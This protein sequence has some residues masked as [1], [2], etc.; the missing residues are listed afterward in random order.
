MKWIVWPCMIKKALILL[1][2][3]PAFAQPHRFPHIDIA[4]SQ[5]TGSCTSV[6]A[7]T[8][9][10]YQGDIYICDPN[11]L[12]WRQTNV[13]PN[14]QITWPAGCTVS[15]PI[16]NVA[17][18]SCVPQG[19]TASNPAGPSFALNFA[20]STVDAFQADPSITVD[21]VAHAF[22]S[23]I[24]N[25]VKN[26]GL[27]LDNTGVTDV[28]AEIQTAINAGQTDFYFPAGTY[29]V[30]T[31]GITIPATILRF[32]MSPAATL[33]Y[34]G[35][36]TCAAITGT[37]AANVHGPI[38]PRIQIQCKRATLDWASGT[39]TTSVGISCT[40][41]YHVELRWAAQ[42]FRNGLELIGSGANGS[43]ENQIFVGNVQDN[44]VAYQHLSVSGGYINQNKIFGGEFRISSGTTCP[45]GTPIAG[46]KYI[47]MGPGSDNMNVF[48]SP[49]LEGSCVE[50][51]IDGYNG[52]N[53]WYEPRFEGNVANSLY[54][55][56]GSNFNG[57]FNPY[58]NSGT[59]AS[60]LS[61]H[62]THNLFNGLGWWQDT[63]TLSTNFIQLSDSTTLVSGTYVSGGTITGTTGQTCV[64]TPT[65][66]GSPVAT[67]TVAIG[68]TP[69]VN[70]SG[71]AFVMTNPGSQYLSPDT[72]ATLSNGTATCSGTAV[73]TSVVG[74]SNAFVVNPHARS[75]TVGTK[76][77]GT[78]VAH[79][80]LLEQGG[81]LVAQDGSGS[82]VLAGSMNFG[83]NVLG[84]PG[85]ASILKL[86]DSSLTDQNRLEVQAVP[87]NPAAG[88]GVN[89]LCSFASGGSGDC[90]FYNNTLST[91]ALRL[92]LGNAG[93]GLTGTNLPGFPLSVGNGNLFHVDASGNA[94][95]ASVTT[96][97]TGCPICTGTT[98]NTDLTGQLTLSTGTASYSFTASPGYVSAPRCVAT[99]TTALNPVQ[100]TVS[101][102]TLTITGTGS[103]VINYICIG[104]T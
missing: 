64:V 58:I 4:N 53:F 43:A 23:P 82:V 72:A 18:N 75:L 38:Q 10:Q 44:M 70:D 71:T 31:V 16:Y 89:Y 86:F 80:Y 52:G 49:D 81:S 100:V 13:N 62:G 11:S 9:E 6:G 57:V 12:T 27:G 67:A 40:N 69:N 32:E 25:G 34:S 60:I 98:S 104:R 66:S 77:Q 26:P 79:Q 74:S 92:H 85:A 35:T 56:T 21:P 96:S 45:G 102:S 83:R 76:G 95:A 46:T 50:R 78:I 47:L 90:N 84:A 5:P 37:G 101:T 42:Q 51:T 99:D 28:H 103:D 93:F 33:L 19:G 63:G 91:L 24:V 1:L 88:G 14:S 68:S 59:Y 48:Y 87:G 15:N 7:N 54:F 94:T 65:P 3:L 36:G 55:E 20:N 73:I 39:D 97:G 30:G 41:C 2:C 22:G 29:N 61:D 17:T 8:L